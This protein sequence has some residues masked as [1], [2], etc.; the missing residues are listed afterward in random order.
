MI[1]LSLHIVRYARGWAV[2][3]ENTDRAIKMG[4]L[5]AMKK[6]AEEKAFTENRDVVIHYA[7]LGKR[8]RRTKKKVSKKSNWTPSM[9]DGEE[10]GYHAD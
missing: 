5:V 4:S 3:I 1:R 2:K 10:D 7:E 8:T 9:L 6:F